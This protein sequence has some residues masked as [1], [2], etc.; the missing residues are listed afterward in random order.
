MRYAEIISSMLLMF[1]L[2]VEPVI[3]NWIIFHLFSY[4][5]KQ[6]INKIF[7]IL[8][9]SVHMIS[10][11]TSIIYKNQSSITFSFQ[12]LKMKLKL[13]SQHRLQK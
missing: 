4:T 10:S 11:L 2:H 12:V 8:F 13:Y 1:N 7:A 9:F 3:L 5:Y 6:F